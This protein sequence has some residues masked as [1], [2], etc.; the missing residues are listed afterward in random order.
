MK[1]TH[2]GDPRATR[3]ESSDELLKRDQYRAQKQENRASGQPFTSAA[4]F[5]ATVFAMIPARS[6]RERK[7]TKREHKT[8]EVGPSSL[9]PCKVP[10]FRWPNLIRIS[11][12]LAIDW[13]RTSVLLL[14]F[15]R[16]PVMD[17]C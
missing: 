4:I 13:R 2:P 5:R 16:T 10:R 9:M 11:Q 6:Q 1:R 12:D 3:M 14:K 17:R 7:L 8:R 15:G